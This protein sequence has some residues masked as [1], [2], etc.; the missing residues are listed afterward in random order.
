M[1]QLAREMFNAAFVSCW[2]KLRPSYQ[3]HL[4]LAL[5]TVFKASAVPTD[6]LTM[7][8]NL[9]EFLEHDDKPLPISNRILGR[10]VP[11]CSMIVPVLRVHVHVSF[12]CLYMCVNLCY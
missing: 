9:A 3:E 7:L 10:F 1:P 12:V 11:Q 4:V 8:L 5:E 6:I 2:S